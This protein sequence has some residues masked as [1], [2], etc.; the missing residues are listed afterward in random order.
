M[1]LLVAWTLPL[2]P[3]LSR[4]V[5]VI[6]AGWV[7][8]A[9]VAALIALWKDDPWSLPTQPLPR[10]DYRTCWR[11]SV[12][13]RLL[14]RILLKHSSNAISI[15][16]VHLQW[17]PGDVECSGRDIY[18]G[19]IRRK[20]GDKFLLLADVLA[21]RSNLYF[22]LSQKSFEGGPIHA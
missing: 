5:T 12:A 4:G 17:M 21:R 6:I 13:H 16:N 7:I 11:R 19:C 8:G 10:A 18:V 3:F 22:N 14:W 15:C 1:I 9:A 2:S 20:I